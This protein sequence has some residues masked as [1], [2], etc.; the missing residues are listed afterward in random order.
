[1]HACLSVF[2]FRVEAICVLNLKKVFDDQMNFR[3]CPY[4]AGMSLYGGY[5]LIWRVWWYDVCPYMAGM[6]VWCMSLYGGYGGMVYVLIW[7]VW[8][9]G[10]CPYM[11]GMVVGYVTIII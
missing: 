9:Y 8:W 11:V 3:V 1:M 6:A 7:W 4:M 2:I 10:V 5:V